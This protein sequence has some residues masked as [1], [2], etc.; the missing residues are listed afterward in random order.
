MTCS[1]D[2][3]IEKLDQLLNQQKAPLAESIAKQIIQQAPFHITTYHRLYKILTYLQKFD[4]LIAYANAAIKHSSDD[5]V[6]HH[7][8]STAFR[9]LRQPEKAISS[10][11]TAVI[12]ADKNML[13]RTD[14]G[15]M[16]KEFGQ[17]EEALNCFE[18][19][20]NVKPAYTP[21]YWYRSD[22]T[23]Q[24]PEQYV[25]TLTAICNHGR[26]DVYACYAL[27]KHFEANKDFQQ[28]FEYLST[29]ATLKR[30]E[31]TYNHQSELEEHLAIASVFDVNLFTQ[32]SLDRINAQKTNTEGPIFICGLPRSGTTLIEQVVSSHQ[33]V[34]AG[35]EL[36]ELAQSTQFILQTCR[37]KKT[38]PFWA[39]ELTTND[40]L[41]IGQRYLATTKH[42]N[43]KHYFTDKMPLNYKAIGL[44]HL[45][46]PDAKIIYC[47]R[48]PMDTLLGAYRQILDRG[49][50]YSYDLDELT[51]MIIAH[52]QL[53][54]HW[55]KLLPE[56]IFIVDYE[57]FVTEQLSTTK[58]LLNFLHLDWQQQCMDFHKNDRVIH[59]ISNTQVRKPLFK[60]AI[61]TWHNYYEQLKPYAIK[62]INAGLSGI[63]LK[64]GDT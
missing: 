8:L 24:L 52:H 13:W 37:P 2:Q 29:G 33:S 19:S 3:A 42:I 15:I 50:R 44:I 39:D 34:A 63:R 4:E 53:M 40:W 38:F 45:A 27:Y 22:I 62:M 23:P 6:S 1:F 7:A 47:Q 49:N 18:Y 14:L 64:A 61:N 17:V 35:D 28:A 55:L 57:T 26:S 36:Y 41:A 31:F 54:N 60:G 12:L 59:T 51:S 56:K 16:Y 25:K 43:T 46:L 58:Q 5:A 48:N 20:I 10:M 32:A 11:K 9:L 21:A 30:Q